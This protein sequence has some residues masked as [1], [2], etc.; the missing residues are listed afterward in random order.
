MFKLEES[1]RNHELRGQAGK[2]LFAEAFMGPWSNMIPVEQKF[3]LNLRCWKLCGLPVKEILCAK[4]V[5][6]I[7]CVHLNHYV[8]TLSMVYGYDP[9]L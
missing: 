6:D 2:Q 7:K 1:L 3:F 4:E 8:F 9:F 5:N